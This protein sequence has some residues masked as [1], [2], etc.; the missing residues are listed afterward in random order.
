MAGQVWGSAHWD[1]QVDQRECVRLVCGRSGIAAT[2]LAQAVLL[3][4]ALVRAHLSGGRLATGP[5]PGNMAGVEENQ[6]RLCSL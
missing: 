5:T 6:T 3:G 2:R 4:L 1:P